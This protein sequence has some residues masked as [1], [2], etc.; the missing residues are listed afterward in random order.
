MNI[1]RPST[2][3]IIA[4]LSVALVA[5]P[6]S[7]AYAELA[8]MPPQHGL[9]ASTFPLLLA[10]FFMSSP[11][12]QTGPVALTALLTLGALSGMA[13][14]GSSEYVKMA[15][16]LAL[17]V[18]LFRLV[19][20]VA[21]LGRLAYLL[22][23]P[24]LTG[25]TTGAA[26]LIICSQ[27]PKLIDG[28]DDDQGVLFD[29]V[30]A[31]GRVDRWRWQAV[32][33]SVGTIVVMVAG[34]RLH[35]LFPGV[36]VA[37]AGATVLSGLFDYGGSTIGELDGGFVRLNLNLPWSSLVGLVVPA[38][39]IALVGF[40]EPSSIA[41]TFAA[42]ERI[43]WNADRE[44]VSQGVAN[45]VAGVTQAF[46]VG[47]SF[48]RSSLNRMA[49]ATSRWAGAITGA[50]VLLALPLT[51]A[52][53]DLP[54]AVL[55]AIIVVSVVALLKFGDMYRLI[56]QSQPQAVVAIGTFV[57]TLA[58]S[59]RVERGVLVGIVLAMGVHLYR[60]MGVTAEA[61]LRGESLTVSPQGVMWFA[62][63]P[64]VDRLIR[65]HLAEHPDLS[66]VII[67]FSG[68][69]RLDFSGAAALGRIIDEI[70]LGGC[71]VR[72]VNVPP[73]AARAVSIHLSD[74]LSDD[75]PGP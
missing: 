64:Q 19:L 25:F 5:I 53:S 36:L 58:F 27:I 57:A 4:G 16:L 54:A 21:R 29:A 68:V 65:R 74:H 15:A 26:V 39:I 59:P 43:P 55:A 2:G 72:V 13:E 70:R 35:R 41:R 3:D 6:Q 40:A 71:D 24:V 12:L 20:G 66:T 42:E 62:T 48:S 34:R 28:S 69:G 9:Y 1:T 75:P 30:V 47:G 61:E 11:Y 32:A 33:F 56:G 60:E 50:V 38:F 46:P 14:T 73:G 67:D 7:L 51:P 45:V 63:V 8:G 18:G 49:G 37:V 52:L 22:S 23:E 31:I 17:L 10:A 44:M